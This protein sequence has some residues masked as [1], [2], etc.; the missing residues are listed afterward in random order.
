MPELVGFAVPILLDEKSA[1]LQPNMVQPKSDRWEHT[2]VVSNEDDRWG[3][4]GRSIGGHEICRG[5]GD[6]E[7][8]RDLAGDDGQ[9]GIVYGF[10]GV[11]HQ[12]ANRILWPATILVADE[13]VKI[14]VNRAQGY[15]LSSRIYGH[16]GRL[17]NWRERLESLG[18]HDEMPS[19]GLHEPTGHFDFRHAPP[20]VTLGKSGYL[21]ESTASAPMMP[22]SFESEDGRI[23]A[24]MEAIDDRL[25]TTIDLEKRKRLLAIQIDSL[26]AQDDLALAFESKKISAEAYFQ[27]FCR[28]HRDCLKEFEDVLGRK[29]FIR[30]FDFPLE[31]APP[32]ADPELFARAHGLDEPPEIPD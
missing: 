26:P 7:A 24:F 30:L 12:I 13:L 17:S 32:P 14:R 9:A 11:C 20:P 10:H 27:E 23:Q 3:C 6:L 5:K 31:N 4:F 8:A 22:G 1:Q 29:D 16:Y 18:S 25:G 28:L 15:T 2:Y 19:F 21:F